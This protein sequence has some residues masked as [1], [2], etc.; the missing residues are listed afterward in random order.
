M[1]SYFASITVLC[2]L[3]V[4]A[5]AHADHDAIAENVLPNPS[6]IVNCILENGDATQCTS[7]AA[8]SVP[9]D[10]EVGLHCPKNLLEKT[11][12]LWEWGGV[13]EGTY[14][15]DHVF[16]EMLNGQD[17]GFYDAEE[18][19][20]LFDIRTEGVAGENECIGAGS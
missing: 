8:K 15:L 2:L 18:K 19:D 5:F 14:L 3:P 11:D 12:G 7:D 6:K 9:E 20:D 13:S 4:V 1:R 10:L 16:F 17:Y